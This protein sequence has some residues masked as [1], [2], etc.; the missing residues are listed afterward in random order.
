MNYVLQLLLL[1]KGQ[2]KASSITNLIK[3]VIVVVVFHFCFVFSFL[4]CSD[5]W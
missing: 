1:A 4:F 5:F 2:V 3:C